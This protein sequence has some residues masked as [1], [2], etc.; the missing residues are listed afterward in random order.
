METKYWD[1]I[2]KH[3][4]NEISPGDETVLNEWLELS[5]ENKKQFEQLKEL[6]QLSDKSFKTY[7]PNTAEQWDQLKAKID[8][9]SSSAKV[10]PLLGRHWWKVAAVAVLIIGAGYLFTGPNNNGVVQIV[11]IDIV[12]QDS[13]KVFHLP[14]NSRI[15]LNKYSTLSYPEL[16]AESERNLILTGEAFFEVESDTTMPFIVTAGNT[17]TKVLG[18]A[19]NIKAY[20]EDEEVELIVA[21]GKVEFSAN[22]EKVILIKHD[23]ITYDKKSRTY[24]KSKA[25]K[26]DLRWWLKNVEKDVKQ[27]IKRAGKKIK[28]EI[29]K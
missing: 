10:I 2:V 4:T 11:M 9:E 22:D 21:E 13:V 14:D 6:L 26:N 12:T 17:Q 15:H 1:L 25:N 19:F 29:N 20:E 7:T 28:R 5:E 24:K 8:A 27:F 16:F 3:F 23:K 18:T